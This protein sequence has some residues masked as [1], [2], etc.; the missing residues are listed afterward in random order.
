MLA[1]PHRFVAH[2]R[3]HRYEMLTSGRPCPSVLQTICARLN[4]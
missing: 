1:V 3:D 2:W 4:L